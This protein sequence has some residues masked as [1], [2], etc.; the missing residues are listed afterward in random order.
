[1]T[2]IPPELWLY[3]AAANLFAFAAF[4]YD[5]ARARA[6]KW[7]VRERDLLLFALLGGAAGA[8]LGR[9][10]FHHKTRK[11][12]FSIALHAAAAVELALFGWVVI[13]AKTWA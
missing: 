3:L 10:A 6:G 11:R 7:R 9:W 13:G 12:G 1:L 5:K 4:G 8:L 2:A